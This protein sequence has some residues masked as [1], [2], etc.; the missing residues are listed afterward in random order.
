M[1]M[2]IRAQEAGEIRAID[3]QLA[4]S[5]FSGLLLNVPR[6]I[7]EGTL[8]GPAARYIDEVAQAAWRIFRNNS[9]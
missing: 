2:I 8:E 7:S 5:H 4:L 1:K 9:N 3:P 6:L